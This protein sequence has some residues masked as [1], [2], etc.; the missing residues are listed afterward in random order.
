MKEALIRSGEE[1]EL[2]HIL[3]II[4]KW[5]YLI[6]GVTLIC[7][8][9]AGAIS[10]FRPKIYLASM[11]IEPGVLEI[12]DRRR[13]TYLDSPENIKALVE[14]KALN[15]EILNRLDA[16]HGDQ[17]PKSM[18]LSLKWP[19]NSNALRVLCESANKKLAVE[20]LDSLYEVLSMKYVE[21]VEFI[22]SGYQTQIDLKKSEAAQYEL[23]QLASERHVRDMQQMI[24]KLKS[25]LEIISK[26][27]DTLVRQRVQFLPMANG[28]DRMDFLS[29][30]MYINA[31]HQN[32]ALENNY[33]RVIQDL[34][35]AKEEK[36]LNSKALANS[37]SS[38]MT[39]IAD[40]EFRKRMVKNIQMIQ[41]PT[42]GKNPIKPK[43]K[44]IVI[45]ATILGLF[46]S[47]VLAFLLEYIHIHRKGLQ[48]EE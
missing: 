19:K 30:I 36:E 24:E 11:V 39:E 9:S 33:L 12:D 43:M 25:D 34:I 14:T 37:Q 27:R 21:K 6:V 15:R 20:I 26:D 44:L 4:W 38:L 10:Y 13:E 40:L 41:P 32:I 22:Q 47:L 18:N 17:L 7:S 2:I 23:Q 31:I 48:I 3:Q 5:K 29:N 8:I 46:F 1:I 45:L 42:V 35:M 16:A 28:E